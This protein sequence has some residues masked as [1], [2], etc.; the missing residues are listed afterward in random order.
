LLHGSIVHLVLNIWSLIVVGEWLERAVGSW[1]LALL[2]VVSSVLGC[3]AS[4]A[5]AEAPLIVGA[6]AGIMG[7]AGALLVLRVFAAPSLVAR[8]DGL[9]ARGLGIATAVLVAL[10]FF[11][12]FIAQ[13]GHLGGLAGGVAVGW[14]FSRRPFAWLGW[15]GVVGLAAGLGWGAS[16]PEWR[17]AHGEYL[18]FEL[19]D[20][21]EHQAGAQALESALAARPNDPELA[22]GVAYGYAEAGVELERAQALVERSLA[23]DPQRADY[24]DTLGWIHCRAGRPEAGLPLLREASAQADG[25]VEEI[26]VHVR[27]CATAGAAPGP[28]SAVSRETP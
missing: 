14:A 16:H 25:A 19:L 5:Y 6:S 8:L 23:D 10:G 2:F 20:R 15:V 12:P 18:G 11:V 9:S 1:R 4:Q 22:N 17:A 27:D 28:S 24:L 3:V 26:E 21:G 7:I 13:A